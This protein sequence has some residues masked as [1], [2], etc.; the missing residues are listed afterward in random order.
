[1]LWA[2]N[3]C[4]G[5]TNG[6][7]LHMI[8]GVRRPLSFLLLLFG[9]WRDLFRYKEPNVPINERPP[10]GL[11]RLGTSAMYQGT[12][13]LTFCELCNQ[14]RLLRSKHCR[15]CRA[16]VRLYD[17]H[18]PWLGQCVGERTRLH[19]C[20]FLL[21]QSAELG[22]VVAEAFYALLFIDKAWLEDA[23]PQ[24]AVLLPRVA[25]LVFVVILICLW[26]MTFGLYFYHVF[27]ALTNL[28]TWETIAWDHIT[29]LKHREK[30]AGSP[31]S[32]AS[33]WDNLGKLL[34]STNV[35]YISNAHHT[36]SRGRRT[37]PK[38]AHHCEPNQ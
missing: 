4:F 30:L 26:L 6:A 1:M 9:P 25:L 27:M 2:R 16:C 33:V 3:V 21:I 29:Y 32:A 11:F 14:W 36:I 17:H 8:Q 37:I 35:L 20:W 31:F 13:R 19:F 38:S 34:M 7:L 23:T 24:P 28:S 12:E 22:W 18:C 15:S 10:V 5:C